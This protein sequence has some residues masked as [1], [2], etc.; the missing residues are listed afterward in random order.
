MSR[1]LTEAHENY[2]LGLWR[3]HSCLPR[4]DSSRRLLW[5]AVTRSRKAANFRAFSEEAFGLRLSSRRLNCP[6]MSRLQPIS[7]RRLIW[8]SV[9]TWRVTAQTLSATP[10]GTFDL[11]L[12]KHAGPG[13]SIVWFVASDSHLY[14][15]VTS[16]RGYLEFQTTREGL[17]ERTNSLGAEP[18]SGFDVDQ[19]GNSWVLHGG[20]SHLTKFNS[21]GEP[22]RTLELQSPI[23][24][25]AVSGGRPIGVRPNLRFRLFLRPGCSSQSNPI[26]WAFCAHGVQ[27]S[28]FLR[29]RARTLQVL[30][31]CG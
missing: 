22:S 8:L 2:R 10:S 5:W 25:F 7:L 9:L 30:Q 3:G 24:S 28:T 1:W 6:R 17:V 27:R 15:V 11:Q 19:A 4:R 16:P 31:L 20:G 13:A 14:F 12:E 18:V 26:D 23:V 29:S 21:E